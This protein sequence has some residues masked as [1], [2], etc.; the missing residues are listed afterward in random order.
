[1]VDVEL[2]VAQKS[3]AANDKKV[4][5]DSAD[6]EIQLKSRIYCAL[7]RARPILLHENMKFTG[8]L[9]IVRL[10]LLVKVRQ[11]LTRAGELKTKFG[12][13]DNNRLRSNATSCG[14]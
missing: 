11:L 7:L 8:E 9:D 12:V 3:T 14:G 5:P 1:M 2:S 6:G 4:T 13:L 10:N